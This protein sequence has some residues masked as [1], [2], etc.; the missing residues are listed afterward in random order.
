MKELER[1]LGYRS[2]KA[3]YSRFGTGNIE[4]NA[5]EDSEESEVTFKAVYKN[6]IIERDEQIA[7][8]Q[9]QASELKKEIPTLRE[10]LTKTSKKLEAVQNAQIQKAS[11]YKQAAHITE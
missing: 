10:N 8:L 1:V 2:L 4:E 3:K 7:L 11:R 6:P 5:F 9:K